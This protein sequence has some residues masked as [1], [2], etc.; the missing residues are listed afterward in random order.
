MN[1]TRMKINPDFERWVSAR[2]EDTDWET[3]SPTGMM[4]MAWEAATEQPL[5]YATQLARHLREHYYKEES[6]KFKPFD[7]LMGVLSQIDNMLGGLAERRKNSAP[8]VLVGWPTIA[9]LAHGKTVRLPDVTLMPA[10]DLFNMAARIER[11]EFEG[12]CAT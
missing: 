1:L 2:D 11:G 8:V 7:D 3:I 5:G 4:Q 12:I 10:D 9:L 6:P